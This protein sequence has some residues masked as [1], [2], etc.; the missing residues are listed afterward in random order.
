[1]N[2][3]LTRFVTRTAL[4]ASLLL[5]APAGAASFR[6]TSKIYD[7]TE[8]QP[9]EEHWVLFDGQLIYDLPQVDRR[10]ITVYDLDQNEITRIDRHTQVQT[11]LKTADLVNLTA[12][13][14]A[15]AT[16]Q[17]QQDR[18]GLTAKV[19]S[20]P[21]GGVSIRFANSERRATT[22]TPR[23][24]SIAVMYGRFVD[25]AL[26]LN[27]LRPSVPPP[28]AQM[29]LNDYIAA[30]GK[31]PLETTLTLRGEGGNQRYRATHQLTAL[32]GADR[33]EIQA[34]RGMLTLYREVGPKEFPSQ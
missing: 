6:V 19:Q 18:L 24:P 8:P 14:R 4:A 13:A 30:Q 33:K 17:E 21:Q 5:T 23:D 32:S 26:R 34:V 9:A 16:T 28:F 25:L 2:P 20:D 7:G 1:M 15:K 29:T 3:T 12:Q 10:F 27:I 31:L 22:Q 11:R